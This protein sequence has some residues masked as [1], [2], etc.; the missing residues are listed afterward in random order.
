MQEAEEECRW[1]RADTNDDERVAAFTNVH[2]K[3]RRHSASRMRGTNKSERLWGGR[4]ILRHNC[5]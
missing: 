5:G 2:P 4:E 1:E 3:E